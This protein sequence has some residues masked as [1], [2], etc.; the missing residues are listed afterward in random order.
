MISFDDIALRRGGRLLFEHFREQ[1]H[2]GERIGLVGDNG[3]GKT[4]LF[5]LVRGELHSD[6]G[7][8]R[9][10]ADW[11]VAHVAQEAPATG[12]SAIDHVLDGDPELRRLQ[13]ELAAIDHQR[14]TAR[15]AGILSRLEQVD[16]YRAPARAARLLHG[17]GFASPDHGRP[18]SAFS[19]GWRVRLGLARALMCRSDLL[20]LDEPTNH[21]DLDAVVW[22]EDWLGNYSGTLLLISHDR[23]FL[24]AICRRIFHIENRRIRSYGGNYS[25]F[26]DTRAQSLATERAA[27]RKQQLTVERMENHIRR[28]RAKATKARQVQSRIRALERMQRIVPAHV[29]SPFLFGF[30][31][32]AYVSNPVIRVTEGVVGYGA[33]PVLASL[34]IA[35]ENRDRI[36]LV[37]PNG[38]GKSTLIKL[39]ADT[40]APRS[41]R[42][43]RARGLHVGYFAQHQLEQLVPGDTPLEHMVRAFPR[44]LPQR[45]RDLLGGFGFRDSRVNDPVGL[46]SGGEKAR[47]VLALLVHGAPNLL[48]MDE[49]TNHLDLEMRHALN[50]AFQNYGGAVVL[51]SH[52]RHL[53]RTVSDRLWLVHGG[54]VAEFDGDIEDYL[55]WTRR[56]RRESPESP[57][58]RVAPA[59]ADGR[60]DPRTRR[61]ESARRREQAAPIRREIREIESRIDRARQSV[62]ALDAVLQDPGTYETESAADPARMMRDRSRLETDIANW[63]DAWLALAERL[64]ALED[65]E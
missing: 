38:A 17:L 32:P 27:F 49:P 12:Q 7:E 42:I 29:H 13:A 30:N 36:A 24:D 3:C 14:E 44:D 41:G 34:D 35:I 56:L 45:L 52:D 15:G 50:M 20:L 37:G 55:A 54:G 18:V 19:G 61:R 2:A 59:A 6:R 23:E 47:L 58:S 9:M 10:P 64:E 8:I 39:L 11:V 4:S 43:V 62:A 21:L 51:V 57:E 33:E 46:F 28:F 22:L 63:E 53:I 5:E 16:G 31:R 40:I 48:L 1:V 65:P 60:R 25:R 26:E